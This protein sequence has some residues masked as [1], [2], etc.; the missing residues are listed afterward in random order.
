MRFHPFTLFD[1]AAAAYFIRFV[2]FIFF[3]VSVIIAVRSNENHS[4]VLTRRKKNYACNANYVR[5]RHETAAQEPMRDVLKQRS[6]TDPQRMGKRERERERGI[7]RAR[8]KT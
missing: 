2:R 1:G 8:E 5:N 4:L 7:A 3:A 6:H